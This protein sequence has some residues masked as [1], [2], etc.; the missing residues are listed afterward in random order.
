MYN[1]M[2]G[3]GEERDGRRRNDPRRSEVV[4]KQNEEEC[5]WVGR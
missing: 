1:V 4:G 3:K 5:G 2:D